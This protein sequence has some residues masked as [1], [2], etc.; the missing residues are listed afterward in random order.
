MDDNNRGPVELDPTPH[1]FLASSTQINSIIELWDATLVVG[2]NSRDIAR[3]GLEPRLRPLQVFKGHSAGI[4]SLV[5]LDDRSFLSS[6]FDNKIKKWD[7]TVSGDASEASCVF[8]INNA[9]YTTCM[10][11]L[12]RTNS[13]IFIF[14]NSLNEDEVV[15]A[16]G[17]LDGYIRLWKLSDQTCFRQCNSNSLVHCICELS[18][19]YVAAGWDDGNVVLWNIS[20]ARFRDDHNSWGLSSRSMHSGKVTGLAEIEESVVI[21]CSDDWTARV[22]TTDFSRNISSFSASSPCYCASRLSNG[23]FVIGYE[24]F[25]SRAECLYKIN[26]PDYRNVLC[27]TELKNGSIALGIATGIVEIYKLPNT[28]DLK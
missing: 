13:D 20:T 9:Y 3:F 16:T 2:S 17:G 14:N 6:S 27:V 10:V 1:R 28:S 7:W 5:E 21:S 23:L 22:W 24:I 19:G 11:V 8:T 4:M 18:S 25:N 15:L 12:R 26:R